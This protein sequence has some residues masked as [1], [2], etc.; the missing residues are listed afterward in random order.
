MRMNE[1]W[2]VRTLESGLLIWRASEVEAFRERQKW[3]METFICRSG[4][5]TRSNK[6]RRWLL[7]NSPAFTVFKILIQACKTYFELRP[8]HGEI[9]LYLDNISNSDQ[10]APREISVGGETIKIEYSERSKMEPVA[11]ALA[12]A[13]EAA[14]RLTHWEGKQCEE[15]LNNLC[16]NLLLMSTYAQEDE[17]TRKRQAAS[18]SRAGKGGAIA[19]RYQ[20]RKYAMDNRDRFRGRGWKARLISEIQQELLK[21]EDPKSWAAEGERARRTIKEWIEPQLREMYSKSPSLV[22]DEKPIRTPMI[23]RKM[24]WYD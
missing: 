5:K 17:T 8:R 14:F 19:A 20:A 23:E 4:A 7:T 16:Y 9:T 2:K 24:P 1:L 18:D 11:L 12:N 6:D 13:T 21:N 10:R 15:D 22:V 3:E